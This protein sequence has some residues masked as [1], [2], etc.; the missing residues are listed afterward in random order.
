LEEFLRQHKV[1]LPPALEEPPGPA[2]M[3]PEAE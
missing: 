1:I 3:S 2:V